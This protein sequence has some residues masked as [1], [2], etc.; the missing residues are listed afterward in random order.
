MKNFKEIKLFKDDKKKDFTFEDLVKEI[1]EDTVNK[2]SAI[3]TSILSLMSQLS[4]EKPNPR[5]TAAIAQV[6]PQYFEKDIKNSQQFTALATVV[7][8]FNVKEATGGKTMEDNLTE[9]EKTD[10]I[11]AVKAAAS[12]ETPGE[13][14]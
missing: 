6:L 13:S 3:Q 14:K 8:R 5:V 11:N 10:L 7:Q 2:R 9:E 1:Y 4:A 12:E